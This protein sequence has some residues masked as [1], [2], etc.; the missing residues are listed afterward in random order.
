M[1]YLNT[2]DLQ[3]I[4]IDWEKCVNSIEVAALI[5]EKLDKIRSNTI[6]VD[7]TVLLKKFLFTVLNK[8]CLPVIANIREIIKIK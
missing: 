6:V 3:N 8:V 2:A 5:L 7:F 4:G 1:L